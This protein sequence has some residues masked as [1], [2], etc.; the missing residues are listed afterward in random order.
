M[1]SDQLSLKYECK[2]SPYLWTPSSYTFHL[3]CI[4]ILEEYLPLK[5]LSYFPSGL[6]I[7]TETSW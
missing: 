1:D 3:G 6:S 5:H 7:A 4:Y 2:L